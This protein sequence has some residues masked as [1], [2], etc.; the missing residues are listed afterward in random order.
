[1]ESGTVEQTGSDVSGNGAS[2]AERTRG[3]Q[4]RHRRADPRD[5]GRLPG[6]V[7]ET[8]ARVRANQ[9]DW[10]ALGFK[11]RRRWLVQAARLDPRPPGEIADTMQAETGKVRAEAA[12]E[13]VLPADLINF[14]GKKAA[15]TSAT[16]ASAPLAVDKV[17]K[18]RVRTG[19][20]PVVGVISP[21]NFPLILSL[22][23]AIPA[24]MAGCAVVIKPSEI[25]PLGLAEIVDAWKREIGA[26]DVFDVVNGM[27]E[28]GGA[29]VD[30]VDF[31]QFTAPTD[32][33][34]GPERA[35]E[36]LTPV[37]PELGGKDPMIVCATPTSTGP[38]TPRPGGPANAGQV[39]ISVER[40]YV[41]EPVYDEFVA[42]LPG[43]RRPAP[44][45]RRPRRH[46][47][48]SGR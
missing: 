14:Y 34:E 2:G 3:P 48:K 36:T 18:L 45:H 22:G 20:I 27:G 17:K 4:P 44:G 12:G 8:V 23:D 24:L 47:R 46:G 5:R 21:W 9:P 41:E 13:A 10:E 1:M 32:R 37:S 15:S 31:V 35:A 19:P 16:S 29:L 28:T 30:E 33:Q 11:G 42:K 40:V 38:P 6:S 26:P 43:G 39:C 7:G 25:T